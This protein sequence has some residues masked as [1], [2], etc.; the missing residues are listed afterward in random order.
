MKRKQ[1][2]YVCSSWEEANAFLLQIGRNVI[3]TQKLQAE[4]NSRLNEIKLEY[5]VKAKGLKSDTQQLELAIEEFAGGAKDEFL[6]TRHKDLTFGTV[7]YRVVE[8]ISIRSVKACVNSLKQL[9]LRDYLRVE[10]KPNKEKL[11]ELDPNTLAKIGASY[12]KED[13]IR[14]EPNLE[15][16]KVD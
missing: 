4:M 12:K 14:I 16:I 11:K 13:K 5:D 1:N 7:A 3:E 15:K 9:G 6:K 8:K 2:K 10:E